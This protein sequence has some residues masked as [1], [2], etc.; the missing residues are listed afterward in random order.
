MPT[1]S[2]DSSITG[3]CLMWF[4]DIRRA[5][6]EIGVVGNTVIRS[7]RG[8]MISRMPIMVVFSVFQAPEGDQATV[9]TPFIRTP[10]PFSH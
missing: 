9:S 3:M 10:G 7:P 5:L 4:S 2:L 8:V 6:S 1:S